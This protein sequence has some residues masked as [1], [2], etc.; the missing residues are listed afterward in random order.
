MLYA[1]F[2]ALA[3]VAFLGNLNEFLRGV[4]KNRICAVLGFVMIGLVI[5]AFSFGWEAG[6]AAVA[7]AFIFVTIARPLAARA[8]SAMFGAASNEPRSYVGLPSRPLR[9]IS[10]ELGGQLDMREMIEEARSG[11]RRRAIAVG[12]LMDYVEKQPETPGLLE[13]FGAS[14][15][16]LHQLYDQLAMAGAGQWACGHWVVASAFAYPDSLR[17]LLVRRGE[18]AQETAFK[19]IMHFERGTIL[20]SLH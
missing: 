7:G 11:N 3:T 13:E 5:S 14:R 17:Y 18:N 4:Q 9:K 2:V 12:D 20:K 16:D 15:Q 8:A 1:I 10:E 19:L 6:V